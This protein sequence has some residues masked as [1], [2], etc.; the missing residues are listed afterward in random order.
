M[1][2]WPLLLLLSLLA[3]TG[4]WAQ[5]MTE[6]EEPQVTGIEASRSN[7]G[8][9]GLNIEGNALV[10]RF[11]DEEKTEIKPDA[12]RATARWSNPQKAGQQRAVLAPSGNVLRTPAVVRPPHVF[13]VYL[14]LFTADGEVI[15]SHA[16]NIRNLE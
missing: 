2:R 12:A 15:E 7:G 10:L 3:I 9:L 4:A 1:K 16:F 8:F 14:S 5:P 13:I 6:E 11:Y